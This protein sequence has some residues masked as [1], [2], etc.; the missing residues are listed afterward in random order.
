MNIS[1]AI[2]IGYFQAINGNVIV[3]GQPV[4]VYDAYAIPEDAQYPYILLSTQNEVERQAKWARQY[5]ATKL[6]DIVTGFLEP[7]GRRQSE[8]IADQIEPMVNPITGPQIDITANGFRIGDTER[9]FSENLE[10][11]NN[12]YYVYRK[13]LRYRLLVEKI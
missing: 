4:P 11:R 2:R 3:D 8:D 1:T 7:T 6:I 10:D 5:Y 9:Q 13:L 12:V